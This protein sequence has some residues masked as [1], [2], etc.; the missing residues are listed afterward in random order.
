LV[1]SSVGTTPRWALVTGAG[2]RLGR[3]IALRAADAGYS[4]VCHANRSREAA[5]ETARM[6]QAR[7]VQAHV[8]A[9][10]LTNDEEV[11]AFC[12]RIRAAFPSLQLLVHNAG[13]FAEIAFAQTTREQFRWHQKVN[14]E[15][16]FFITQALLPSLQVGQGNIVAIVDP[17]ADRPIRAHAAYCASKAALKNL[18]QSMAIEL[19]PIRVNGVSPGAVAFPDD[20][21]A[22]LKERILSRVPL[23]REGSPEDIARAVMHFADSP[24]VTGQILAVDGGR[25][26]RL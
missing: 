10:D 6:V 1:D 2:I 26:C 7:G 3:A 13:V 23:G 14:V 11:D 18:V 25:S 24:Y 9:C 21:P 8:D 4:V 20:Y 22:D 12:V 16:P 15:A 19:A 17:M 5:H